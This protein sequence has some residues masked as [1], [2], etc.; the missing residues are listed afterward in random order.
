MTWTYTNDPVS[1]PVDEVRLL[2]QDTDSTDPLI[3]DEEINYFISKGG[4]GV[5]A[6]YLA[7]LSISAKFGRLADERTGQIEVKW[8]QR[9]RAYAALAADL[10]RQMSLNVCPMPY[11]GGTSL[12]DIEIN[13]ANT[14]RNQEAFSIGIMDSDTD[15]TT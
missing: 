14:D 7:A 4:T 11:A 2:V 10:K 12:S 1:V 13:K 3:S 9:A 15:N 6:A 5:G 8:S